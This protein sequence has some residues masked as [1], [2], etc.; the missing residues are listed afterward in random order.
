[1]KSI[2]IRL[3]PEQVAQLQPLA[4]VL[5]EN[6]DTGLATVGQVLFYEDETVLLIGLLNT[7]AAMRVREV[8]QDDDSLVELAPAQPQVN[9]DR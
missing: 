1:M 4:A 5:A 2:R 3:T 7:E 6:C 8:T 9:P